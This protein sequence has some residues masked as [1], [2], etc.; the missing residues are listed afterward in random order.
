MLA[1]R[2]EKDELLFSLLKERHPER[3]SEELA[4]MLLAPAKVAEGAAPT[5][6]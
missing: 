5:T 2:L 6:R 4:A 1:K 3:T